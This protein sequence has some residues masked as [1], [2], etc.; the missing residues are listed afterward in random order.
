VL[1][2]LRTEG[3]AYEAVT[4][5][6]GA[7]AGDWTVD[8]LPAWHGRLLAPMPSFVRRA[9]AMRVARN[10]VHATYT[11]SRATVRV[12]RD[13]GGLSI[14][15]SIFCGVR[16]RA[17]HPL[18]YF[19]ASAVERVLARL[20]I[21]ASASLTACQAEGDAACHVEVRMG[22]GAPVEAAPP[23]GAPEAPSA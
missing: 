9:L 1:S 6:A 16:D 8:E 17:T 11:G 20:D 15:S 13:L 7:Y 4:R 18:C 3:D 21:E 14:R 2:F 10:L 22:V 23:V 12:R 5:R 19:Y